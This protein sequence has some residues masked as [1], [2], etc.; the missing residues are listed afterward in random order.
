MK[1]FCLMLMILM[2]FS[3]VFS[4]VTTDVTF[5]KDPGQGRIIAVATTTAT[6]SADTTR[7]FSIAAWDSYMTEVDSNKLEVPYE[8]L[9]T[10]AAG[11]VAIIVTLQ[12]S[13][14]NS[15]WYNCIAEVSGDTLETEVPVPGNMDIGKFRSPYYRFIITGQTG[16]NADAVVKLWFYVYWVKDED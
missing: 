5:S 14:D 9:T 6:T 8:F 3:F 7:A 2:L 4:A 11:N 10:S 15:N 13:M 16:N 1:K 12:G